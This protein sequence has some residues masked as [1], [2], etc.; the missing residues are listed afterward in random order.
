MVHY[1]TEIMSWAS[2]IEYFSGLFQNLL[3]KWTLHETIFRFNY[4]F[5]HTFTV[6]AN[7][8]R[9]Y[10][11]GLN[12]TTVEAHFILFFFCDMGI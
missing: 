1:I 3:Y 7:K 11:V 2:V 9:L 6:M 10:T 5:F 12:G 4:V 8:I